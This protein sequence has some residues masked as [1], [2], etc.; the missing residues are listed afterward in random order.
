MPAMLHAQSFHGAAAATSVLR[1]RSLV[2]DEVGKWNVDPL[3]VTMRT[4]AGGTLRQ[5]HPHPGQSCRLLV[6]CVL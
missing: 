2:A 6:M 1:T 4:C 3:L 5:Q